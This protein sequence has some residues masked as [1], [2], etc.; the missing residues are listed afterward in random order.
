MTAYPIFTILTASLNREKTI[1]KSLCSVRNQTFQ[2]LEQIIVDGRSSD[3]TIEIIKQHAQFYNLTWL[4][5]PDNGIAEA[6]NKGLKLARG[7]YI[8]VLGADDYLIDGNVLDNVHEAIQDE[9]HD[10]YSLPVIFDHPA[11]GKLYIKPLRFKPWHRFRN[12]FPHQGVFV[13]RRLFDR[14]GNFS[15]KYTIAMD[16]DFFYRALQAGCSIKHIDMPIAVVG[17]TGFSSIKQYLVKRLQEEIQIQK[18]NEGHLFWKFAQS[19]FW[20]LYIPY[21]TGRITL[22]QNIEPL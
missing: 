17:G 18:S 8:Y 16:Y 12:I 9:S 22:K 19:L 11:R 6:L 5:E 14:V 1:D 4:S 3:R 13:H 10:I 21:K 20:T 2:N 7:K 15:E